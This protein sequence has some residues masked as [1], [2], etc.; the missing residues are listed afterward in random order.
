MLNNLQSGAFED[1][2]SLLILKDGKLVVEQYY[3]GWSVERAHPM[4]SVSKGITALLIGSVLHQGH[5]ESVSDPI[6][7]YLP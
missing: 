5:I 6:A 4:Q 3:R 2:D 7:K 1:V